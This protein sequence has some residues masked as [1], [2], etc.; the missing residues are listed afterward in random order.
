MQLWVG[1]GHLVLKTQPEGGFKAL[2]ISPFNS[3]AFDL[4]S[5]SIDGIDDNKLKGNLDWLFEGLT[6]LYRNE[7]KELRKNIIKINEYCTIVGYSKDF[8]EPIIDRY[9][10]AFIIQFKALYS[11]YISS[12]KNHILI[13]KQ[14]VGM[15]GFLPEMIDE[16]LNKF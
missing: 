6:F 10:S 4:F 7:I 8:K 2:G 13:K 5:G 14:M 3:I 9:D 16:T 1:L 15:L 11:N 12:R